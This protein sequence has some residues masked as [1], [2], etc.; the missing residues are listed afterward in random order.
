MKRDFVCEHLAATC[1]WYGCPW[2][3]LLPIRVSE[4]VASVARVA[5]LL[6]LIGAF[7]WD[8]VP[9]C[10]FINSTI[11]YIPH[12]LRAGYCKTNVGRNS[13]GCCSVLDDN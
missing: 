8:V 1:K 3:F 6:L 9:V 10:A 11:P 13:K 5:C 4:S 7:T 2:P 12:G